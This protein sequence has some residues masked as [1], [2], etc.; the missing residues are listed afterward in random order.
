M[1]EREKENLCVCV[2]SR[3][4][5]FFFVRDGGGAGELCVCV[6]RVS[7]VRMIREGGFVRVH[8]EYLR[9]VAIGMTKCGA[10]KDER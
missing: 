3:L 1:R 6:C 9:R 7:G 5:G 4:R 10:Q 8:D 2:F